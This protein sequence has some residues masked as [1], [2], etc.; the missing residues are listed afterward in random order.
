MTFGNGLPFGALFSGLQISQISYLWSME[1][2]GLLRG[3]QLNIKR[4]LSVVAVMGICFILA[5]AAGPSSAVLLIPRLGYWPSGTT[6][7]WINATSVE[8][9]PER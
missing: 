3:D 2:W 5:A 9:W 7:I 1:F 6:S 8:I 4:K